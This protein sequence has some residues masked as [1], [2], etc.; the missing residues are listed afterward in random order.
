MFELLT[1][2]Y[3]VITWGPIQANMALEIVTAGVADANV[4]ISRGELMPICHCMH[5]IHIMSYNI[6]LILENKALEIITLGV[7]TAHVTISSANF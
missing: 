3:P 1:L 5:H 2:R 7:C 6:G 4:T